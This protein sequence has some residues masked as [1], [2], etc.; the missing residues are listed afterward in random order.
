[1]GVKLNILVWTKHLIQKRLSSEL[2]HWALLHAQNTTHHGCNE[3]V[4]F[5]MPRLQS[6]VLHI[7]SMANTRMSLSHST[8]NAISKFATSKVR[9]GLGM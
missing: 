8:C 3:F 6:F 1:M 7:A 9:C 5:C 2:L 4:H